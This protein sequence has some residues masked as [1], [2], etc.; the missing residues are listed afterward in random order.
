MDRGKKK[1]PAK[2]RRVWHHAIGRHVFNR[3]NKGT[4][5]EAKLVLEKVRKFF[6]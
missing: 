5:S 6:K 2:G 4:T 3:G 1:S